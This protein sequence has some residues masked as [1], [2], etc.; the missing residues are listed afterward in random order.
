MF[1]AWVSFPLV[2]VVVCLGCGLGVERVSGWR[3]PGALLPAVGLALVI[4]AASLTTLSAATAPLTTALV[5][6]LALTGYATSQARLRALAPERW[7]TAVAVSTFAVCAAPVVMSGNATFLG[8]FVNRDSAFHFALVSQLLAHG[9]DLSAITQL[10][11]S[12]IAAVLREYLGTSYPTGVD[13]A[14]GAL[15]PLVGEDVAWIYQ[16]FLAMMMVFGALALYELLRAIVPSRPLVAVC[17][18][19][20]AE[21]GLA[22]AFYLEGSIKEIATT[23]IITT[24]VVVVLET[25]RRPLRLRALVPLLIIAVAGLD[26]YALAAV[27]WLGVPLAVFAVALV[28]RRR[29]LLRRKL[30][31]RTAAAGAGAVVALG[32]VFAALAA[33]VISGA[34]T[35]VTVAGDV[36]SA[37]GQLGNLAAPL[38]KWEML[39]IWP[40]GDFRWLVDPRYAIAY[41]LIGL[42]LVSAVL[43][44]VWA[45]RR[46]A[47]GPLLLLAG[48]VIATVFLLSRS[49]PYAAT[50]VM[51]IFSITAVLMAMLGAVALYDSGRRAGGW[52]L[53]GLI[54]AAVMWTN[55]LGYHDSSVAPQPRLQELAEIGSRFAGQGPAFYNTYDAF[56]VYFLRNESVTVPDTWGSEP[57]Q[58]AGLTPRSLAT[59]NVA[60]DPNEL[61][62]SYLQYFRLLVLGRSP[63]TS[64]PPADYRLAYQGRYY[65]VWQRTSSPQILEHVA[66]SDGSDP[67]PAPSCRRIAQLGALAARDR[68]RLAYVTRVSLPTFVPAQAAH[69]LSW[70]NTRYNGEDDPDV[71]LLSQRAGAVTGTIEVPAPGRYQVWLEGSLS[72]RIV[73]RVS[74]RLVGSVVHEIGSAGEF[75]RVGAIDLAAGQQHVT[76]LRP[77]SGLGP[78]N[79]VDG[80]AGTR[81]LLG[82]L[83]LVRDAA[84]PPV[85]YLAPGR[86][87]ALC[88]RPLE[89]IEVVS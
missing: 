17:A 46:R 9:R 12:S 6:A 73:V 20:A 82:P 24:T 63:L 87:R 83:V 60:W 13:V 85:K 78:G 79:I 1:A 70:T 58:R 40:S 88:G 66:L 57:V 86:A 56:A 18:F 48:N 84:P 44:T 36:L 27:P 42:A 25:L 61:A 19:I 52:A 50:K 34:S 59:V 81:D 75:L 64:R 41:G 35:F 22:Y 55:A 72:R 29:N 10:P 28:W 26:V 15:R 30:D 21:S 80:Y 38:P 49:S 8:Y 53:V 76:I 69:P 45:V 71:L 32:A 39:G 37:Q 89:W 67:P 3:L 33:P 16:P 77:P 7:A 2:M 74:G 62:P 47:Y 4:V 5:V 43:G 51:M 31:V 14:L 65:D 11:S 54:A 23:M 68:A